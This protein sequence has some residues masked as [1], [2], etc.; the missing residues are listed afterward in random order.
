MN[1][2]YVFQKL[3]MR[4]QNPK[5]SKNNNIKISE[6]EIET[7]IERKTNK[8]KNGF[9]PA[10]TG[11]E[12]LNTQLPEQTHLLEPFFPNVGI[13]ALTGGSDCGK[14][15][16]LRQFAIY[17]ASGKSEFLGFKLNTVH[18]SVIYVS[19]EDDTYA[20]NRLLKIQNKGLGLNSESYRGLRLITETV[21][22]FERL[23]A[24]LEYKKADCIIIDAF[25]DLF[26]GNLNQSN[27]VRTFLNKFYELAKEH[28]CFILFLHHIGKRGERLEPSKHNVLGS[29]GFE[30][31]MRIVMELRVDPNDPQYR[32][33]CPVKGNYLPIDVK[34]KSYKLRF[35]ENMLY[36]NTGERSNLNSITEQSRTKVTPEIQEFILEH[37]ETSSYRDIADKVKGFFGVSISHTHVS[38]VINEHYNESYNGINDIIEPEN[39]NNHLP[40]DD[41]SAFPEIEIIE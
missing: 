23:T 3:R 2:N 5:H 17:I 10:I 8:S 15:S 34:R 18:K 35:D 9:T 12:L 40:E 31:K 32:H 27:E 30:G 41:S 1:N 4:K 11:E 22:L 7:I 38:R 6:N 24:E 39:G 16:W 29:V 36:H 13:G 26:D 25:S 19:T 28:N 33:M 37:K 14:S 21:K 20:I